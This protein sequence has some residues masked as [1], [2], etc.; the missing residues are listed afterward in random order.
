MVHA[1]GIIISISFLVIDILRAKPYSV[2]AFATVESPA[3]AVLLV[4]DD[5]PGVP[6]DLA[7]QGE[8]LWVGTNAGVVRW[9]LDAI[10]P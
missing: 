8:F 10:R 3:R 9:R 1:Q 6:L 5:L 2:I 7:V 4:G